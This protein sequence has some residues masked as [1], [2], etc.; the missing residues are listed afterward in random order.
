MKQNSSLIGQRVSAL[1]V[2]ALTRTDAGDSGIDMDA[3]VRDV[4]S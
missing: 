2:K 3:I 4:V 1:E